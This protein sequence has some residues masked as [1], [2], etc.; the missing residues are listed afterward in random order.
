MLPESDGRV[1]GVIDLL[2]D[3]I[4]PPFTAHAG[5]LWLRLLELAALIVAVV[6]VAVW[7]RRR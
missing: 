7:L 6:L 5:P 4:L 2:G 1:I 3:E